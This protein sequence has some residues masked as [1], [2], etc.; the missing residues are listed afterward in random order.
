MWVIFFLVWSN[1]KYIII[2]HDKFYNSILPFRDWKHKKGIPT[3]IESLSNIGSTADDIYN[4][5]HSYFDTPSPPE[6]LL[7]VGDYHDVPAYPYRGGTGPPCD[8]YYSL[9]KGDDHLPDINVGRFPVETVEECSILVDKILKYET[10]L[11]TSWGENY[12]KVFTLTGGWEELRMEVVK[13][14]EEIGFEEIDSLSLGASKEEVSEKINEGRNIVLYLGH[15]SVCGWNTTNFSC[16]EARNLTN[17]EKFLPIVLSPIA[18][19]NGLFKYDCLAEAFLD[20]SHGGVGFWGSITMSYFEEEGD[21]CA[22]GFFYGLKEGIYNFQ[23]LCNFGKLYMCKYF[24]PNT[25]GYIIF[26]SCATLVNFIC[27]NTLTQTQM[28]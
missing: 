19:L 21:S 22:I 14:L 4:Y 2:T 11:P 25:N 24:D 27:V 12:L 13:L 9:H 1:P 17:K 18:C 7:L 23:K 3:K 20:H 16:T 26:K 6:Y 5:I 10:S 15:G 28:E 8:H